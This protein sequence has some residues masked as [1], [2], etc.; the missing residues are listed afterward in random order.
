MRHDKFCLGDLADDVAFMQF[1]GSATRVLANVDGYGEIWHRRLNAH[2][3][4]APL[5]KYDSH[6]T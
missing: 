2:G 4:Q 1:I 3:G 6:G 5:M